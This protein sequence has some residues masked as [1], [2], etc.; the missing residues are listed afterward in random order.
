MYANK[1]HFSEIKI[2][3]KVIKG[4]NTKYTKPSN[5]DFKKLTESEDEN[6]YFPHLL[7]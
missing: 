3:K 6:D 5:Y 2:K 7:N 1:R 4:K